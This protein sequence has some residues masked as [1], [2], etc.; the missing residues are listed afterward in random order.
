MMD[1]LKPV[2]S[3]QVALQVVQRKNFTRKQWLTLHKEAGH[4]KMK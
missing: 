2:K 1:H 3:D 4:L